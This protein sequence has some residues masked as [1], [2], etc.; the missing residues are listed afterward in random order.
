MTQVITTTLDHAPDRFVAARLP[1]WLKQAPAAQIKALRER[2][3]AHRLSHRRLTQALAPLQTPQAFALAAYVPLLD[4]QAADVGFAGLQW[5]DIRRRFS[6]P[7]G[8]GL[9]SDV[10]VQVRSP[11]LLRLMQNFADGN[12]SYIGSGLVLSG[13]DTVL[14]GDP[15]AF[16]RRCRQLDVGKRYQTLL[17]QQATGH[18]QGLLADH[19]R[20]G[21]ALAVELASLHGHLTENQQTVL[22]GI[23][24]GRSGH[25]V[26]ALH[27]YP[28]QLKILDCL[29]AD[30]LL[31]QLRGPQ[32]ED[33]GVVLYLPQ[34]VDRPL[35]HFPG[36]LQLNDALASDLGKP[37]VRQRFGE[38]VGLR[39]RAA[40]IATLAKRLQD[41][42]TDLELQGATQRG[43]V[44]THLA[45]HH[46]LRLKDDARLLLVPN[47]DADESDAQARLARWEGI[48]MAAVG[49]AGLFVPGLGELLLAQLL[50]QTGKETYE[51]IADWSQGHQHEALE[52]LLGVAEVVATTAVIVLGAGIVTRGIMRSDFVD[53]L[54]PVEI[55]ERQARLWDHD[56]RPFEVSVTEPV[57]QEDGLF[58]DGDRR[59]LR[60]DQRFYQV[61]QPQ[62]DGPWR[63]RHPSASEAF[64]PEVHNNGERFWRLRLERPMD[65]DDTASMLDRLWPSDPPLSP[66][67]ARHVLQAAGMDQDELRGLLVENRPVPFNLRDSL[68]RF[69][70]D[71]RISRLLDRLRH[72]P[73][74]LDDPRILAWCKAQPE[75]ETLSEA[76]IGLRL[77]R[78]PS[79][80]RARLFSYLSADPLPG[81]AP[82]LT[83]VRRDFPGLPQ[84]YASEALQGLAAPLQR[85]AVLEG[86][87][88]LVVAS[89]AR[90]L[91]SLARLNRAVE[92]LFLEDSYNAQTGELVFALLRRLPHWPRQVNLELR[93][94]T[95]NG[96]LLAR[97]D[98]QGPAETRTVLV[99]RE[100]RFR[101]Y[102]HRG[103][104]REEDVDEPRDVFSAVVVLLGP[105]QRE[106]L[107]LGGD[108]PVAQLRSELIALLPAQRSDVLSL[109][110][111]RESV[112]WVNPGARLS[113]GRVGYPLGGLVSRRR[114]VV[115]TF[116][117]RIRAL[118]PTFNEDQVESF[119]QRLLS[120]EG[121][122]FDHLL[123]HERNYARL[124]RT[125][126]RWQGAV[127]NNATRVQRLHLAN[128]L[129]AAWR[130]EGEVILSGDG[131]GASLRLNLSGW[132]VRQLP[133]LP[134]EV[135]LAHVG[136]LILAGQDLEQVPANFLRCF[137]QLHTLTVTNNRLTTI[138]AGILH[139]SELRHLT[140]M[141]NRIRMTSSNR[142]VLR[143]LSRLHSLNL[144]HNPLQALDLRFEMP[145]QLRA[146]RLSFCGLTSI[147]RGLEQCQDLEF[148]DLSDNR[149]S[150]LPAP[151][152]QRPWAFRVRINLN[153]N[154]LPARVR[155]DFYGIDQHGVSFR[156]ARPAGQV[157]DRWLEGEP[158]ATHMA[159]SQLWARLRA[160]E[161][162]AGL[163]ELLQALT[164]TS[165][166]ARSTDYIRGQ[167]WSLLDTLAQD[168][169]LRQR[170]F[171]SAVEPRGCV[172]SVAER[173]SRLQIEVLVYKAEKRSAE[174]G[175]RTQLLDLG[176]R[177]FRL[178]RVDQFAFRVIRQRQSAGR[179]V[180]DLEVVL[181][182]RIRLAEAL[183]LPC[184]PHSMRF[185]SLA[186]ITAEDERE[187][188]A[189]VRAEET[190]EA[191]AQSVARQEFWVAYLRVQHHEAFAE[192]DAAF[193]AR[194]MQLDEQVESL[195]S[196]EYRQRWD[197]LASEREAARHDLALELTREALSRDQAEP[198]QTAHRD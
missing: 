188:L 77:G 37:A 114:G 32:G 10:P 28:G 5:L 90:S 56:L 81:D 88:P 68:R 86:R 3:A 145:A 40:F 148:A 155:E 170:I 58:A 108:D 181:G 159:R 82:M 106:A 174:A 57:L 55:D 13:E 180:D 184:Q 135:D 83:L 118:Y 62:E 95:E 18:V 74:R 38:L 161:D 144:S 130:L 50:V 183:R 147:P 158:A 173:F 111:W 140:L 63:L 179:R 185:V 89:K 1:H 198:G 92:G 136:E 33:L 131:R 49:V 53:R 169:A 20:T 133:S 116:R 157:M 11:A 126:E 163:F 146:L 192:I 48:G 69:E 42:D 22:R 138:P 153:R 167:V 168:Q 64:E 6:V 113:N 171:A 112:P 24:T 109:L 175:A 23:A 104:P 98:P 100:G 99:N 70:A 196:E 96:R 21:F 31:V 122:P 73:L 101:L 117:D 8:Q 125:L 36:M 182:Y 195:G 151:L 47:A 103:L 165:D 160:R 51:G 39:E 35:R 19:K 16:A 186:A 164:E 4:G 29:A 41:D 72:S 7:P 17:Q 105:A 67:R 189:A 84:C 2:Y 45:Q 75:M 102:D 137:G 187:A 59:L 152:M 128:Q 66:T 87:V 193:D 78:D 194:G 54:Q 27:A 15:N 26:Q 197:E 141:A 150:D 178:E 46:V 71:A 172:D 9:P 156:P 142:E 79:A 177:L 115:G 25:P 124:D 143:S 65:W 162:S 52:H 166:F 123:Q 97:L 132:R 176:R 107:G 139:L 76:Q 91:L 60:I 80:W 191:V 119:M 110:G 14:S 190:P 44:F 154:A 85:A 12:P 149:I 121:S 129:R 120:E 127:R 30:S 94:G 61:H 93:E 134:V 43:D 34:D